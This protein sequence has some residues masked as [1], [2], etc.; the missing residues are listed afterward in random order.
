M[1]GVIRWLKK[2]GESVARHKFS[3]LISLTIT[4]LGV[5]LYVLT[6]VAERDWAVLKFIHTIEL[7]TYDTRFRLRGDSEPSPSIAIV[8]IDQ[9]TLERF[10]SWPFSRRHFALLVDRLKAD[11][12]KVIAFDVNFPRPDD[13]SGI[14]LVAEA[15][16]EYLGRTP[17][18]QRDSAYVEKL[19]EMEREADADGRFADALRRAG[20]AVLGY[21]FFP[22]RK[23]VRILDEKAQQEA[24]SY[25]AFSSYSLRTAKVEG[26]S[27][28]PPLEQIFAGEEG[29]LAET[30]LR[31][32]TDAVDFSTG[33]FNFDADADG[34]F[35]RAP[36][37]MMYREGWR[38][39]ATAEANFFPSLDIQVVRRYLDV[40]EHE[41][42]LF[43]NKAGVEAVFLGE[44]RVPT[45]A[46][47]QLLIH[48]QGGP[49]TYPHFSMADVTEG[50]FAKGIFRNRIV[51]VGA[52]ALGIADLHPTPFA[53]SYHSGVEIH[54]NLIDTLLTGHFIRRGER[55]ILIDLGILLLLGLGVGWVLAWVPPSWTA[56]ITIGMMAIFSLS[57]YWA[58]AHFQVWLNYVVPASTLL[59]N[60]ASVTAYR[61]L[62]EEKQKRQTYHAFGRFV[63]P[64]VVREL[65]K[66]PERLKLGGEE[67]ELTIMFS[68]I[69]GFTALTE[70]LSP[71]E[72]T[73]FLNSYTDDM[74]EII[75]HHWGTL[76]KFE[77]D[78]IMAFWGAPYEQPDHMLRACAA[79]LDMSRRVDQLRLRWNAEGKG[80]VDVGVG[81]STGRVVVGNMGS[82]KR[83]NY[84][85][86][87]DPVNLAS[88]LEGVTKEYSTRILVSEATYRQ[89]SDA[90][91]ILEKSICR[92]FG[93]SAEELRSSE[94][95]AR[96]RQVAL[97][98]C[99]RQRL[100]PRPIL[101]ERFGVKGEA[102]IHQVT[103]R[104]EK[105]ASRDK[106]LASTLAFLR[107]SFRPIVFRP[108][109]WIRVQGRNEPVRIYEVLDGSG[110]ED[111]W[112]D[113]LTLFEAGLEAYRS[114]RWSF[115]LD[116]FRSVLEKYPDDGP[117]RLFAE[118]CRQYIEEEPDPAWDG[119]YA[120]KTK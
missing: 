99:S 94:K 9:E 109:D 93:V 8:A 64:A 22:D 19:E 4:F 90:V 102:G 111:R 61:V 26:E 3:L 72:L 42:V 105:W 69:R 25:L 62:I 88:R 24:D 7:K 16:R 65:M 23:S 92:E 74:T 30:N 112:K 21:F 15:K 35:R 49:F 100:A 91:G 79:A 29:Y 97:Y 54:A 14:E 98:I 96:A 50:N 118:R 33:Y 89:A 27:D 104:V 60:F 5:T 41:M 75:F 58:L 40:P 55:E 59:V 43:S 67:R 119:V 20:N 34:T 85:V 114:R 13:K 81:L 18:G 52:T 108:L 31:Q 83:F 11:G 73:R 57:A 76:D 77:G 48:Y 39:D 6:Y 36:L 86:L 51:L 103:A 87:G 113:L 63:P 37:A 38:E 45:D 78:A 80:N 53:E 120:M 46:A 70:R 56:P 66:D 2:L 106:K 1:G 47:G 117:S 12:A 110:G 84:T 116:A 107:R 82:K 17:A 10:G 101:A 115:A 71:L 68:D 28:A 44:H 32:F 95:A